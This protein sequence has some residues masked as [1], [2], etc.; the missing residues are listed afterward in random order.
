MLIELVTVCKVCGGNGKNPNRLMKNEEV[1]CNSC[2]GTGKVISRID[3]LDYKIINMRINNN[4]L[5]K[6]KIV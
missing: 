2:K 3:V 5:F 1:I 4:E 6:Y